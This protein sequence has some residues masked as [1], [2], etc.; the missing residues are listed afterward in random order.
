MA[1]AEP[2][3]VDGRLATFVVADALPPVVGAD[4]HPLPADYL[5]V[6][7]VIAVGSTPSDPGCPFFDQKALFL[8][9]PHD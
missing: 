7:A 6:A 2:T 1:E 3:S 4:C 5:A 8:L 9:I